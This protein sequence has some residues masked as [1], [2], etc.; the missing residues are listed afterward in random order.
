MDQNVGFIDQGRRFYVPCGTEKASFFHELVGRPITRADILVDDCSD[1]LRGWETYGGTA[2]KVR[3]PENG[4]KGTWKG[5][6]FYADAPAE[7]I[8]M[9]LLMVQRMALN[10]VAAAGM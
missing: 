10:G 9:Y 4:S 2:V 6:S 1:V 3:T 7:E 8:A 5:A